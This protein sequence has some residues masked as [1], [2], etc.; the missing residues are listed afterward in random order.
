MR[1]ILMLVAVFVLSY[2]VMDS[3]PQPCV[4]MKPVVVSTQPY[5]IQEVMCIVS[6]VKTERE[7]YESKKDANTAYERVVRYGAKNAKIEK[8]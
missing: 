3:K 7:T 6:K 8:K 4:G 2:D 5:T 1:K